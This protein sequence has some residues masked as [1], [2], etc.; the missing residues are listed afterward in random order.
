[1]SVEVNVSHSEMFPYAIRL[2]RDIGAKQ[3]FIEATII[4][5]SRHVPDILGI[6]EDGK[7]VLV[8]CEWST[9]QKFGPSGPKQQLADDEMLRAVSDI[10]FIIGGPAK[11]IRKWLVTRFGENAIHDIAEMKRNYGHLTI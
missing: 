7:Y 11:G 4:G 6:K 2:A 5:K 3:V 10:H 9:G 1:M 8:E